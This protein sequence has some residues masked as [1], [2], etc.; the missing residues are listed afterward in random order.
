MSDQPLVWVSPPLQTAQPGGSSGQVEIRLSNFDDVYDMD[1]LL[2]YNKDLLTIIDAN[3]SLAGIQ[4]IPGTCPKP[5]LV[6]LNR[7]DTVNGTIEY[8]VTQLDPTLPCDDGI[9]VTVE[10]AC[11]TSGTSFILIDN[12]LVIDVNGLE[13]AH[14]FED[15]TI[16]CQP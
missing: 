1:L 4:V 11:I 10:F 6:L 15:G 13:L 9:V 16:V 14:D 7:V 2:S 8:Q 12:T 3:S 5:D